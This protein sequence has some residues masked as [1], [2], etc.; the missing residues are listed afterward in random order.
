MPGF[1]RGR[2]GR[3]TFGGSTSEETPLD[4]TLLESVV[5]T[6][7]VLVQDRAVLQESVA[8]SESVVVT[9]GDTISLVEVITVDELL[10]VGSFEVGNI[11]GERVQLQFSAELHYDGIKNAANLTLIPDSDGEPGLK[12]TVLSVDPAVTIL[13]Q[14]DAGAA[15]PEDFGGGEFALES[16]ST[17]YFRL[18]GVLDPVTN[19]GDFLEI[20]TGQNEGLYQILAVRQTG[21]PEAV[22]LLDRPLVLLD[23]ASGIQG[24][25]SAMA[26]SDL[27]SSAVA[28]D[29]QLTAIAGDAYTFRV[30]HPKVTP[31]NPI[32]K[33]YRVRRVARAGSSEP[34]LNGSVSEGRL[35][36]EALFSLADMTLL[37]YRTFR[38]RDAAAP[39]L[40]GASLQ[41]IVDRF[42]TV[43]QLQASVVWKH[44]T[45][46]Q[47]VSIKTTKLTNERDCVFRIEN[48][49]RKWPKSATTV[50]G[51]FR[52]EGVPLPKILAV[53]AND[54][55]NVTVVYDE[56]MQ[57]DPS[58]LSNP[59][60]YVITGPT[61]VS[62]QRVYTLDARSVLLVTQGLGQG[63]YSLT[64]STNTPKDIAGNPLDP[65]FNQ[66]VFTAAQPLLS[67]SVF[68]DRGPIAKPP[69]TL[70]AGTGGSLA[71][72]ES[73]LLP[74]AVFTLAD[75]GKYIQLAGS[76]AN[77]GIYEV[78]SI[79]DTHRARLRARFIVP[80][81]GSGAVDWALLD[82]RT[83]EIADDPADVVVRING[84]PVVPEAVIG[85]KGQI[86]LGSP[87]PT[88]DV[89]VDYSWIKNP[90]VEI[91]RLNSVEFR[92]NAWNRDPGGV[93][94]TSHHY[95]YNNVLVTPAAYDTGGLGAALEQPLLREVKYRGYERAYTA[96]LNDPAKLLFNTPIHR[97]ALAPAS[98]NLDETSVF[99]EAATLPE[100]DPARPWL[101]K[102]VG[103]AV[104]AAGSLVVVDSSAATF[105]T[106]SHLF[107]T[108]S[109]DASFDHV[110]SVAWR[111]VIDSVVVTEGVW[112][113]VSAGYANEHV[114][115]VVGYI[116]E[117]G[118][119]K[120]GFLRRDAD[121]AIGEAAAWTGGLDSGGSPTGA[122]TEFD[123]S[124]IHSYRLFTD[125]D[126]VIRLF[127]DGSVVE[128]LRL[129][130][131][132]APFL[133]ELNAPFNE[134][135]GVFFGSLSRPAASTSTWDFYRY[136]IQPLNAFQISPASF[137]SY[138]ADQ[139][140][141]RDSSPWTPVGFHGTAAIFNA[142]SLLLDSTSA[143]DAGTSVE[144][145]LIGGD[146]RG[147]VKIEPLLAAASRV[148]VDAQVQLL[149]H[150]HGVDPDGLMLAVDDGSR[151]LQLCFIALRG[152][153]KLS[154]GGRSV[155]EDFSPYAWS[156][157]GDQLAVMRGRILRL[158]DSSTVDGRVY[159]I[160]DTSPVAS[161]T[162]VVSSSVDYILETR[163]AV[164]SYVPDG[165]GFAGVFA[166][167]FDG[168]RAVGMM[169]QEVAG[170][171]YV[172]LHSDGVGLGP[173]ARFAF[174]WNDGSAHTYRARKSTTGN[175]VTIFV[176][177][178]LLGTCPYSGFATPP[179]DA[180]GLVS[181]GSA[182]AASVQA[183]SVVDWYYCN[184]WRVDTAPKRY[185]GLWKG[186]E[187]GVLTGFHLPVKAAGVAATV[188]GN[189]LEDVAGGYV[190][191]SIQPG[192]T[193]IVD[194][195]GNEGV[196]EVAAVVNDTKLTIVGV[197]PA[198]PSVVAYRIAR[199]TDWSLPHTYR[200]S[201]D[202]TGTVTV[203]VD[204]EASP[205]IAVD[206]DS[207]GVPSSNAGIV[208]QLAGGLPAIA[209]GSFSAENLEQ[210]LWSFVRYGLTRSPT[211][212]RVVPPHHVLNQWN[213]MESPE[214]LLT[215]VP[216]SRTSF[217]SSS[218]GTTPQ[219]DPD[220]L[221]NSSVPSFTQLNEG[222]PLVPQ[223]Q[224]FETRGPFVTRA[225][226]SSFNSPEDVLNAAE[227][228]FNDGA[229]RHS[230]QV[231]DDVLYTSL[232]AIETDTG[233]TDL[234]AP[235]DDDGGLAYGGVQYQR[236]VCLDYAADVLPENDTSAPT[237]WTLNS[238][239]PDQVSAT[240]FSSVLTYG[241]GSIG[242]R[243]AYFN[244]TPL[245]DA[246]SLGTEAK[247]RLRLAQDTTLGLGD[248]QVRF[249][250]SAPGMTLGIGFVTYSSG[251]RFVE[252]YDLNDGR[253]MGRAT[254]DYLDGNY[255]E[256]RIV[257]N[258][259]AGLVDVFIDT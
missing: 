52:V 18:T 161:D 55:G 101:R 198:Q 189:T 165:S 74:G 173:S 68:T 100:L 21:F 117:A 206:Y 138:E 37:D 23:G 57:Q 127:V 155:P 63:D 28:V 210:S 239:A 232:Q 124:V 34:S 171:R 192:D 108:Q 26:L 140:P 238:E 102:G 110:L 234:L 249:G 196:Y 230:L 16:G 47:G 60:D 224:S 119:K 146:F 219:T 96:S 194:A 176:D 40:R 7:Q 223:T 168:I 218:T 248:S 20:S 54:E 220:F 145:G 27:E 243:T 91:R 32:R 240:A 56:V 233:D 104:P 41:S 71:T 4:V 225:Y 72:F 81:S 157:L 76:A 200:L 43:V 136:L 214:R 139:L 164:V 88:G 105:P 120:I 215:L 174:E 121:E 35:A 107:W 48:V 133:A 134:I 154:Y 235:F 129:L 13:Q 44:T 67:R 45:G 182:T 95:R 93:N 10:S 180:I 167:V 5:V 170:V 83:G 169:L 73:V 211:E 187:R 69:L 229:I 22:V 53:S 89:V 49:F 64:V 61:Q 78:L 159:F 122:A 66:A 90:R 158:S 202:A 97:I 160:P 166:Q 46:V 106:G 191:A 144:A 112:T 178:T 254:V 84:T 252:I 85:L 70:Q 62:V 109:I 8:A 114:V 3:G 135:Q 184:A 151:L 241:T 228:T 86:V 251:E 201:R 183:R 123:W 188:I 2:F 216:H 207:I 42:E 197:W 125:R 162:R 242:T 14:G 227:F 172:A 143:T 244:N 231:P 217:K 142:D 82:L 257:R 150:T 29:L 1:G 177:G 11:G 181:F 118:V 245:P 65:T 205:S 30:K 213:V 99:Y 80:D 111:C 258:P 148:V 204:A 6:E 9:K 256:Y 77:D 92:F 185:L 141:E 50:Q 15:L 98:R 130:P 250:L 128:I 116:E 246:P 87:A 39:G 212:L 149:T 94:S 193:L 147:Y 237:P 36:N 103:S 38:I 19:V 132:E 25:A 12:P 190:A 199:E 208:R 51:T 259:N 33:V 236:E 131:S 203:F 222:T 179:P 31:D 247:F 58:H 186:T 209:F 59:G 175:L 137:V 152:M 221:A 24:I 115:Y 113:G 163:C 17:P 153:P 255:H 126:G 195:G 156:S 253:V 75:I 226:V 79:L